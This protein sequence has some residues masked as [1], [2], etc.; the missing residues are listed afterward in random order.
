MRRLELP[1]VRALED[2]LITECFYAGL[3]KGK[4]DQ[5]NRCGGGQGVGG[6]GGAGPAQ[7]VL[8]GAGEAMVALR[9]SLSAHWPAMAWVP[10][11]K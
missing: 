9:G 3:L 2:L 4:L 8:G 10:K 1:S 7:Q 11:G 5:R 6:A